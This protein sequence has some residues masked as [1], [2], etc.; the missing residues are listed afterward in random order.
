[1]IIHTLFERL[2]HY[3][4]GGLIALEDEMCSFS[5]LDLV[6]AISRKRN[7]LGMHRP[8]HRS[9][10][11]KGDYSLDAISMLWAGLMESFIVLP[12]TSTVLD[13]TTVLN[14]SEAGLI[15]DSN[16]DQLS[17]S[18][19][20]CFRAKT[21]S[22]IADDQP[23]IIILSS[24]STG[25]PKAVLHDA[26]KLLI[27]YQSSKS[28]YSTLATMLFDHIAGLDNMFY[29]LSSGGTLVFSQT[30]SPN[31]LIQL[32]IDHS[33][34][35]IPASPSL[36][37]LMLLE[38]NFNPGAMPSLKI[39]T[40]GSE[41][42]SDTVKQRLVERF[43]PVVRI[44]Q[45]YGATEIGN[46]ATITREDDPGYIRFKEG[47]A[48]FK[49]IDGI[50]FIKTNSSMLGYLYQDNV[51]PFDGWFNTQDKVEV[52]G[53]WIK[54]L[55]RVTD[56]VN[57]GGQK[58]YPSEVESV[59]QSM[60]NVKDAAVYGAKNPIMGSVVSAKVCLNEPESL[61]YFKKRMRVFCKTKLEPFKV[62][63]DIEIVENLEV[64][65]RFKKVR[66]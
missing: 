30:R 62:P 41:S 45:K 31:N 39:I 5:Y 49:V 4:K 42:I 21:H 59:L 50:L 20:K 40:F 19:T 32:A 12:I 47:L 51:V 18:G 34:E 48:E 13:N 58:V 24:G 36:L 60:D 3:A 35:V 27:K 11:V 28:R 57:V 63:V 15:Y 10:I 52:D 6:E 7:L 14:L 38:E 23:G 29:T 2:K 64:S 61:A 17:E 37:Q 56:I 44:I 33:V 8:T 1:M 16:G 53:E 55:G 25:L 65:G 9:L 54:I 66:K 46:P 22:L 26:D 43:S